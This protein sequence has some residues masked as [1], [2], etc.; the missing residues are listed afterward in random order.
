MKINVASKNPVKVGAVRE[1]IRDYEL[2]R[3]SSVSSYV[4][5]SGMSEQP[6]SLAETVQGAINRAKNAFNDCDYSFGIESGF[7][8]LP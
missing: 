5:D 3:D 6:R 4:A 7:M 2:L 1:I 8:E